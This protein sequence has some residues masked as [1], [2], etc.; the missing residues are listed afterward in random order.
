MECVSLN[1]NRRSS[2]DFIPKYDIENVDEILVNWFEPRFSQA[3]YGRHAHGGK[4]SCTLIALLTAELIAKHQIK[5]A[6][7]KGLP[8]DAILLFAKA[9]NC[10]NISYLEAAQGGK[11]P[12]VNLSI[13]EALEILDTKIKNIEEWFFVHKNIQSRNF[14]NRNASRKIFTVLRGGIPIWRAIH[15]EHE[16]LFVILIAD[17]RSMVMCFQKSNKIVTLFDPHQHT[18]KN[19]AIIVQTTWSNLRNFCNWIVNMFVEVYRA[20]PS[21]YELSFV[22][23]KT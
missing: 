18:N 9:M 3:Q 6:D 23:T 15:A 20:R 4:N 2:K 22:I 21:N 7:R 14:Y 1:Y 11:L 12:H 13:P 16:Y 8:M 17:C 19:G 10:G 5:T